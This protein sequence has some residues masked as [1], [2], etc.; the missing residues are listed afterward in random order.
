MTP[1]TILI[2]ILLAINLFVVIW[3][4]WL[5]MRLR[6]VFGGKRANELEQVLVNV[7]KELKQVEGTHSEIKRRLMGAE[8]RLGHTIRDVAT[9]R[10]NPFV[11]QGS[12]QSFATA[13]L[14]EEGDGVIVSSLYSRENV[15]V[16]SKPLKSHSSEYELSDEEREALAKAKEN[17]N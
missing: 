15:S 13:F 4:I 9:V 2:F 6:K 3:A 12:N 5:H 1:T 7:Q 17:L 8:K 16:Y 11:D 10:F 14:T